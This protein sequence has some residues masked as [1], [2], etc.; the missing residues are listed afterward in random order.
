MQQNEMCSRAEGGPHSQDLLAGSSQQDGAGFGIFTLSDEGEILITDQLDLKQARPRS[1][2]LLAQL[3][4]PTGDT[5][6]ARPDM[7]REGESKAPCCLSIGS[8]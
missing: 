5:S 2:V 1:H 7:E 3:I 6:T 4:S 8:S